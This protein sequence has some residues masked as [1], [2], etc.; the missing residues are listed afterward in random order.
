MFADKLYDGFAIDSTD[1]RCTLAWS[2]CGRAVPT[3]FFPGSFPTCAISEICSRV[4]YQICYTK[5]QVSFYLWLI[6]LVLKH[7][8]VLKYYDHYCLKM[9]IFPTTLPM[10]IQFFGGSAYLAQKNKTIR[11]LPI[12]KV[13]RFLKPNLALN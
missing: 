11:N 9:Y 13:V 4:D 2:E 8:K 1:V 7:C 5:C 3:S 12:I 10:M 6:G